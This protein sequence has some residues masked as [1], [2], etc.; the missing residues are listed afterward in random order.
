MTAQI[1]DTVHYEGKS[2][3]LVVV[4]GVGLFNPR[5]H[6]VE[7]F[8]FSTACHRGYHCAYRVDEES[9]YLTE[10]HIGL[11]RLDQRRA[12]LGRGPS[13]FGRVPKRYAIHGRRQNLVTGEIVTSW[14]S[15]DHRIDALRELVS[16]SG[17]LLVTAGHH[18]R[19]WHYHAIYRSEEVHALVF[20]HG[21]LI[22]ARDLSMAA[23]AFRTRHPP[24]SDRHPKLEEYDLVSEWLREHLRS[25]HE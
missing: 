10:L 5:D 4:Q 22:E 12:Q 14:E 7:P 24:R 8:S 9:L 3:T 21:R 25:D 1:S 11:S 15:P 18:D 16:F 6:G 19:H 13:L 17:A 2:R 20:E 23:E